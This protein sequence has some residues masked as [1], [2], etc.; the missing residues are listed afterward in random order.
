[1]C[2]EGHSVTKV[3]HYTQH[4]TELLPPGGGPFLSS[5]PP[6]R[7]VAGGGGGLWAELVGDGVFLLSELM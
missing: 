3:N 5:P 1:M 6:G 2:P 7:G 4:L